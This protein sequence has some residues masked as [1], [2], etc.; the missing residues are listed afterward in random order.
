MRLTI[1]SF[2]HEIHAQVAN[3]PIKTAIVFFFFVVVCLCCWLPNARARSW[4]YCKICQS[5][6]Q[7]T[8]IRYMRCGIRLCQI[9]A[10]R[11][12]G[13]IHGCFPC[14]FLG[15]NRF[16]VGVL[17]ALYWQTASTIFRF[18]SASCIVSQPHYSS[19]PPSY[20]FSLVGPTRITKE[21]NYAVMATSQ[22]SVSSKSTSAS[23]RTTMKMTKTTTTKMT[24]SM[25]VFV[26]LSLL[27]SQ[28]TAS[29]CGVGTTLVG[30][31][32]VLTK[33]LPG[34]WCCEDV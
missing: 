6:G 1:I 21:A 3:A 29:S 27:S 15:C 8:R 10:Y 28:A 20:L 17:I 11:C 16:D 34:E 18:S 13:R 31:A 2:P 32:C 22:H 30:D 7:I 19:K 4:A 33:M 14:H 25:C 9:R 5:L 26:L 24:M 12:F 23:T